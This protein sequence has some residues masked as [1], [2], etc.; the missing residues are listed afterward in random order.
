MNDRSLNTAHSRQEMPDSASA[1]WVRLPAVGATAGSTVDRLQIEPGLA[2]VRSSFLSQRDVREVNANLPERGVLVLTFG[3]DGRSLYQ[4][5]EGERLGFAAGFTTAAAFMGSAGERRYAA[6]ERVVQLRLLIDEQAVTQWLGRDICARLMPACG[7][8]S[9]ATARTSAA[10]A[11]HAQ[12]LYRNSDATG[13]AALDCRI[14]ALSLL[15]EE[16]R[17]LGLSSQVPAQ[18]PRKPDQDRLARARD[19]MRMQLDRPLTV[20]YLSAEVGMSETRFK[21]G[22]RDAF[23]VPPGQM[24][25][26]LRMER[27]RVLLE[28]GCQVAQAAWQVG[29]AHPGNFSTAFARYFGRAPTR[30]VASSAAAVKGLEDAVVSKG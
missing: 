17:A 4:S 12:A 14:H 2:V 30:H 20:A 26:Q 7:V 27:A 21:A 15:V 9:L 18:Q 24:L 5:A 22:F 1:G 28:G 11:S 13:L 16:I 10:S 3:L 8:R 25:L 29:Y 23:G 6:G 19:L